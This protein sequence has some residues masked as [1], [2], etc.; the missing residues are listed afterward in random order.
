MTD[1][2]APATV[3]KP[4]PDAIV[5]GSG[6]RRHVDRVPA[7]PGGPEGDADREAWA[8]LGRFRPQRRHDRRRLGHAT[9][10]GRAVYAINSANLRL[11]K[12]LAEELGADFELRL[13]GTLTVAMTPESTGAPERAS[14][15]NAMRV[16]T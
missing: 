12:G 2:T 14:G 7:R 13:P 6:R 11:L 3:T 5:V 9:E 1:P 16:S 10:A 8:R 15:T 4:R